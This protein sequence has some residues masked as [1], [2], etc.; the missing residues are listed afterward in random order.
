MNTSFVGIKEFRANLTEYA[1]RARKGDTRY[2]I[3]NRN[4]PLFELTPFAEDET[5]DSFVADIVKAE[6]DIATGRFVTHEDILKEL[7]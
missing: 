7:Q 2:V 4:T 5:L 6:R 3:V 1:K